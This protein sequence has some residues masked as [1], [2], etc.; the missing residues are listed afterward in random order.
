[1]PDTIRHV[2]PNGLTLL[3]DAD[4]DAE[5]VAAGYFVNTGA[6]DELPAEMGA[7]HF[8]EHLLFKGSERLSAAALN[9]RLDDLGGHANAFTSE[10]ATVYHAACLPEQAGELLNTLTELMRPALRQSDIDPERGV[11]LEEIAMYA[12][13][14]AARVIDELHADYWGAH[15]LGHLILGTSQTVGSLNRDAL[16]RNHR[17]RYGAGRVILAVVGAFQPPEVLAWA[18]EHLASW[19]QGVPASSDVLPVPLHPE[20]VRVIPDP[21]LSRV[22]VALSAP[23]LPMTHP[24]REAAHVLAD[25]TGGE[26]GALYWA[27]LDTGLSDSADLTHLEYRDAGVFEGGFSCD[28]H[29]AQEAL[30]TYRAVLRGAEALITEA[31]VRRAAKKLAVS[32]LLRAETPQGRL[33]TL[34]MEY[35]YAAQPVSTDQL[36]HRYTSVTPQQVREVLQLCPL[37][38]LTVVALGPIATLD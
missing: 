10:E 4:P 17:E 2:L 7:S 32:T 28:P 16:A 13:Q 23:G 34:G 26:N 3:L 33:F 11:I 15:P 19:P 18:D 37:D 38:K 35:L 6:R 27:L 29:R 5:T 20:Q 1:M 9:E 12:D 31:S 22:Q 21:E 25:L 8:I 30:T 14:P 36:V 24:L